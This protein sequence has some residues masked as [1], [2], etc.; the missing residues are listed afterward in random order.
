MTISELIR[1]LRHARPGNELSIDE[2]LTHL[3]RLE[4]YIYTHVTST[5]TPE[6]QATVYADDGDVLHLPYEYIPLYKYYLLAQIDMA[7]GDISRY[8][9][10]MMLY[11]ALYA[12]YAD[13]YNRTY[14]PRQRGK[15]RWC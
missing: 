12:D 15:V 9:N 1:E 5:H 2:Y 14:M 3:N 13:W 11:N 8:T 4:R 7:S 6:V 10:D